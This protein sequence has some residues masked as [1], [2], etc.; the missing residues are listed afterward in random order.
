[1]PMR[2]QSAS[3]ILA[4]LIL[5]PAVTLSGIAMAQFDD[6]FDAPPAGAPA[7]Q[8][9]QEV[10]DPFG[11]PPVQEQPQQQQQPPQQ[12][13]FGAPAPQQQQPP[14]QDQDP[15]GD[16]FGAPAPQQPPA[17]QQDPFGAPAP[18]APDQPADPFGAPAP[19]PGADP[20]GDPFGD[21]FSGPSP[22][23]GA[24][25][26]FGA[27]TS[28]GGVTA[29][30]VTEIYEF[31]YKQR[32]RANG[33]RFATRQIM[34][35]AEAESF[36]N[37]VIEFYRN[38][39][40]GGQ[41]PNFQAEV[42]DPDNWAEWMLYAQQVELW[43][44]YVLQTSLIGTE[45]TREDIDIQWPG[46]PREQQDGQQQGAAG[47]NIYNED[48]SLDDQVTDFFALPAGGGGGQQGQQSQLE[49]STMNQQMEQ[50][51]NMVVAETRAFEATEE[52]FLLSLR[53]DLRTRANRRVAYA[54]WRESQQEI[55]REFVAD[56]QRRY[57]GQVTTI[58]GVR[59]E[60]YR[61]EDVPS[62]TTRDA[63][64]VV[65]DYDL[66]PYDILD[67]EGNLRRSESR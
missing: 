53:N 42:N 36:D 32:R 22:L 43:R 15:F 21:P 6:P 56:W 46:Q 20:F 5:A 60:L 65:T 24:P 7:P 30:G 34:T 23:F 66:T 52:E 1:M 11:A 4:V 63:T 41:L 12:D 25:D 17:Q 26:D 37:R 54:E 27:F 9:Q 19:E 10:E 51:Y 2:P 40:T 16:P 13:P 50:H 35:R 57:E 47:R 33:Q 45:M 61:P 39:A 67:D 29:T 28:P 3:R 38:L 58:A 49:P 48:R 8:Q 14:A 64:I 18:Q 44:D 55:I 59:Y 31:R 62:V